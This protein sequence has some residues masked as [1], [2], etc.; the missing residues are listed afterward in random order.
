MV[1]LTAIILLLLMVVPKL[2][3]TLRSHPTFCLH[4][5]FGFALT[6]LVALRCVEV[7]QIRGGVGARW[8][9]FHGMT[10]RHAPMHTYGAVQVS[11]GPFRVYRNIITMITK[12][13]ATRHGR[14]GISSTSG[15]EKLA[16]LYKVVNRAIDFCLTVSVLGAFHQFFYKLTFKL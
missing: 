7:L 14:H 13:T 1:E 4:D 9:E 8:V 2:A 16:A 11:A 5:L 15:K 12:V 10:L 3:F 6:A